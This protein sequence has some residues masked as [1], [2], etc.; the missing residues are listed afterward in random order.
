VRPRFGYFGC[1]TC[2]VLGTARGTQL[3][4]A[5]VNDW[6]ARDTVEVFT[7]EVRGDTIVG[8]YRGFGGI[9]RFVRRR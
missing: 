3:E 8:S 2:G 7:G 1:L 9:V 6:S 5:L 4:L